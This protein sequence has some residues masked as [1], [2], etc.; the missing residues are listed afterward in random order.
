MCCLQSVTNFDVEMPKDVAEALSI[1][2][3]DEDDANLLG[4]LKEAVDFISEASEAGG[5]VRTNLH[6]CTQ[7]EHARPP[8]S[9]E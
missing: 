4:H 2:V 6:M 5:K 8:Q 3:E 7:S 1:H 9:F